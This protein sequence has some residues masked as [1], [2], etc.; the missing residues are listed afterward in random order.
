MDPYPEY[1]GDSWYETDDVYVDYA[2]DG[3]YLYNRTHPG[4]AGIAISISF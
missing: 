2:D 3:Y 1:W 4:R